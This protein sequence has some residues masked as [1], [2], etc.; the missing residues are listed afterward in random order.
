MNFSRVQKRIVAAATIWG[1]TV[2]NKLAGKEGLIYL[3]DPNMCYKFCLF[4]LIWYLLS[5]IHPLG[6]GIWKY[7]YLPN[8]Q[9]RIWVYR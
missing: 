3:T 6:I 8:S 4:N 9:L 5:L 1:N 7:V 2:Y